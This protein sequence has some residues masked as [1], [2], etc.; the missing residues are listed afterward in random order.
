MGLMDEIR[1]LTHPFSDKEDDVYDE[2]DDDEEVMEEEYKVKVW[3]ILYTYDEINWKALK[4]CR[5][6]TE[7][8]SYVLYEREN[9]E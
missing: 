9:V 8:D 5:V 3:P 2:Y 4:E 6:V 7:N 1:K